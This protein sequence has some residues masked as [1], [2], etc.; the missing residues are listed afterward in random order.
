MADVKEQAIG[1]G[2][3]RAEV[4]NIVKR[5]RQFD[6]TQIRCEMPAV[7]ADGFEDQLPQFPGKLRELRH[8]ELANV[9]GLM[10]R[11][12]Q[13]HQYSASKPREMIASSGSRFEG[14]RNFRKSRLKG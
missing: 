4:V 5:K 14:L 12:E 13:R 3:V 2:G 10:D 8:R 9:R 7:L 11:I 1:A 6:D